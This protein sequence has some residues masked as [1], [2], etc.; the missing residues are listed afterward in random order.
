MVTNR[1]DAG[2]LS[3]PPINVLVEKLRKARRAELKVDK[4]P[5]WT[6]T[7]DD[8]AQN[9][10]LPAWPKN[11]PQHDKPVLCSDA[12]RFTGTTT[13][14][15]KIHKD[16]I[17]PLVGNITTADIHNVADAVKSGKTAEF[18]TAMLAILR[19]ADEE[20]RELSSL[21][22]KTISNLKVA[23]TQSLLQK[24]A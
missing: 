7:F 16:T 3:V 1:S 20:R 5:N 4:K 19:F 15:T 14:P 22:Q 23:R 10:A 8:K 2:D 11:A 13:D 9:G 21:E 24:H 12:D 17:K 6:V 18:D